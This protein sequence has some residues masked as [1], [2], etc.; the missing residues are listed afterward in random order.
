MSGHHCADSI[1]S[2]YTNFGLGTP[3]VKQSDAP[4]MEQADCQDAGEPV[5][6][7]A[8]L[9]AMAG[10]CI[11]WNTVPPD[12]LKESMELMLQSLGRLFQGQV[13]LAFERGQQLSATYCSDAREVT[14]ELN[15]AVLEASRA[16][17]KC[18]FASAERNN[19]PILEQVRARHEANMA[20]AFGMTNAVNPTLGPITRIGL[21][22][23]L[24]RLERRHSKEQL[25]CCIGMLR[26]ELP[27]WLE[28][29]RR[30]TIGRK[31]DSRWLSLASL[32]GNRGWMAL[33]ATILFCGLCFAPLPY[34][35]S[36]ECY[37]EPESRTFIASP[38]E[39]RVL[40]ALVRPG[41]AVTAGQKLAELD[42][43]DLV[44][45][46][47]A[48]QAEYETATKK[49]DTALAT[50]SAGDLRVAQLEQQR[51]ATEIESLKEKLQRM[52]LTSP[53]DGVIVQ[54][55][56]FQNKGAPVARGD[57]IF[58]I[59]PLQSMRVE[60]HLDTEDLAHIDAGCSAYLHVDGAHGESWQGTIERIDARGQIVEGNVVFVA[61]M[62][63]ANDQQLL[64]PGMR[65]S[66]RIAAGW[67]SI[68]WLLFQRPY[69][70]C[71][72]Q[73]VW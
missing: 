34:R 59:A 41:D 55:D 4:A 60:V 72:K 32:H 3:C 66:V 54:G 17:G 42:D 6:D 8:A 69:V 56:W 65:G 36:R 67:K 30:S 47:S 53:L 58:E 62:Q 5:V 49:R 33:L 38:I 18:L 44:W 39:G 43:R 12:G 64:R 10:P 24:P 14:P 13:M 1:A 31:V 23:C 25:A 2:V 20:L 11:D 19:S 40:N 9:S 71:M 15:S 35:P 45:Q 46:L 57:T 70:W 61:E 16:H 26:A 48:A 63:V 27:A 52:V 68:G 22:V 7:S 29:W 37:L 51:V 21:V 73:L 50:R 28:V